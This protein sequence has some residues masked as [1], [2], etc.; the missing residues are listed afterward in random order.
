MVGQRSFLL[1]IIGVL[2]VEPALA[3]AQRETANENVRRRQAERAQQQSPY[4]D[5]FILKQQG[6]CKEAVAKLEPLANRGFGFEDAQTALGECYLQLA[7]LDVSGGSA[8]D[9]QEMLEE[10]N[11]TTALKWIGKSA[12][13]GHFGAQAVMVSLYAAGL[14]PDDDMIEG[15]KWAHLYLTNPSRLNL[16]APIAAIVSIDQMRESMD[17]TS[18]LIGKERAR[19]WVPLY[20]YKTPQLPG[21]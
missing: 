8:P 7:G 18:W 20:D 2:L 14:G 5:G 15:A 10:P 11:F 9:R 13:A 6:N 17:K 4:W 19:D 1:L 12:R 16:G 3:Q 21:E